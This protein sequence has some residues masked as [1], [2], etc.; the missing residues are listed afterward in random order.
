MIPPH[1]VYETFRNYYTANYEELREAVKALY[2]ENPE[3][4]L[5]INPYSVHDTKEQAELF[6]KQHA[7]DVIA[8]VFTVETGKWNFFDSFKQQRESVNFYNKNTIILEEMLK[9]LEK[10]QRLGQ[11]IT[12]KRVV[13]KKAKNILED[14]PD[15]E[16]F[17]KW[18]DENNNLTKLGA[19]HIGDMASDD[20]EDDEIEVP[21]WRIAKGGLEITRDRIITSAEAPTFMQEAQD[22]DKLSGIFTSMI[23]E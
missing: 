14:G 8:E 21:V 19:K 12:N 23:P 5:A 2:C 7:N 6:R 3:F 18:T 20:L 1:D 17:K 10:D 22:R 9:Q 4:E 11:A 16:N 13:T 15:A